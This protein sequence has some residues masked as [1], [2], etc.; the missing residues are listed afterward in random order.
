MTCFN[1]SDTIIKNMTDRQMATDEIQDQNTQVKMA[2][3]KIV[4]TQ[5]N[6]ASSTNYKKTCQ[7]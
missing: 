5:R 2:V 3:P 6:L 4:N 7:H 1:H